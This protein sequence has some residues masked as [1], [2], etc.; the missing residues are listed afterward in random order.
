MDKKGRDGIKSRPCIGYQLV[1][2]NLSDRNPDIITDN[3]K[4]ADK[5]DDW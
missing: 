5:T 3:H 2:R 4:Q 1:E